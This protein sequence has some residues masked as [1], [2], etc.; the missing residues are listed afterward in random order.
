[1]TINESP[2]YEAVI[3]LMITRNG[4]SVNKFWWSLEGMPPE[5]S[6]WNIFAGTE[7]E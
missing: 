3:F 6:F 1:M 5:S 4:I 2:S 7:T